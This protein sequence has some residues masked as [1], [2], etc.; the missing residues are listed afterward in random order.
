MLLDFFSNLSAIFCSAASNEAAKAAHINIALLY[1]KRIFF[2]LFYTLAIVPLFDYAD[3]YY[4]AGCSSNCKDRPVPSAENK[5]TKK[6][7]M[8]WTI[9]FLKL[10]CLYTPQKNY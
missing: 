5:S 10:F 7:K 3:H 8:F 1:R 9:H 2:F 6:S 4:V